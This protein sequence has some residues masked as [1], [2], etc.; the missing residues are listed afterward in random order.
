MIETEREKKTVKKHI[1]VASRLES[2][3]ATPTSY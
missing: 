3:L 2:L 1:G